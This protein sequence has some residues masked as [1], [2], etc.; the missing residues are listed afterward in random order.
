[1]RERVI[2]GGVLLLAMIIFTLVSFTDPSPAFD[3]VLFAVSPTGR[4]LEG[5]SY[6]LAVLAFGYDAYDLAH[7]KQIGT[8]LIKV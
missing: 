4:L 1:M 5:I 8:A 7:K 6:V 3:T 2:F